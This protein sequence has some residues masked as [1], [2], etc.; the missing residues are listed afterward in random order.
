MRE[1]CQ[2]NLEGSKLC[3][4]VTSLC[5]KLTKVE[6]NFAS[7]QAEG[8]AKVWHLKSET[9][10]LCLAQEET[11]EQVM[12]SHRLACKACEAPKE[13]LAVVGLDQQLPSVKDSS[14]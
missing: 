1:K 13:L 6:A 12:S 4:T 5:G 8:K 2:L 7:R 9:H 14:D 3:I 10:Q 11:E